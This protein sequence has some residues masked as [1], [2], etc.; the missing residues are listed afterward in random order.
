MVKEGSKKKKSERESP[1]TAYKKEENE[2]WIELLM[3]WWTLDYS[4]S[5]L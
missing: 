4:F 5:L 2:Y 1:L 3:S